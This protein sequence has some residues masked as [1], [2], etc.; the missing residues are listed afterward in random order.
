MVKEWGKLI[1]VYALKNAVEH[2]G[3]ALE[4]SIIAGLFHEGLDKEDVKDIIGTIKSE[5]K[6][7]NSLTIEEQ[8]K[9]YEKLSKLASKRE[10]RVGLQELPE[11]SKNMV[12]RIAPEP[13]KYN[14]IGHAFTFLINYL[15][16]RK[17]KGKCKLRF[18]DTNPE[19]AK[20]EYVD[21]MK[22]DIKYLGIEV[23]S[24]RF[25]SDDMPKL[26][27]YSEQ[28]IKMGKAF[29]CFCKQEKMK[30]LREQGKECSCRQHDV[31][32]N[33]SE[34]K[35]FLEGKYMNGEAT[36]RLKGIMTSNN[37]V[38]RD[39]VI[40]RVIKAEHYKKK[41]KVWPMYD[42]YNP[43]EDSLMGVTHILRSNEF[44]VRVELHNYIRDLL[45]L[46][47][48][49]IIQYGRINVIG[50]STKGREIRDL[51]AGKGYMGWDDPRLVTLLAL[52]R[53]GIVKEAFYELVE[54]IGISNHQ[55]NLSF[56]MIA[57]IN[58]KIL[59][60]QANRYSFVENPVKLEI[61]K[62]PD[63]KEIKV[64]VHPD[65]KETRV[66]EIG[67][68]FISEKDYENSK[69]KEARLMHLFN[70]N[71]GDKAEFA[72]L[73][74]KN[75]AR[76]NWVSDFVNARIMMPDATWITGIAEIAVKK[77]KL[78]SIIQFERF[79]FVRFDKVNG[80]G[81]YEFWFAHR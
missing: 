41:Y 37:Y 27:K 80:A 26:Y 23:A 81:E 32:K 36:L 55:V 53:R 76:I 57:A 5:V 34:W 71:L 46:K 16:A 6:R 18:E 45:K 9:Q 77:L 39:P 49:V 11:V 13:S 78:G 20:K 54:Q 79:G 61:K 65:K 52:R 8:K 2:E 3:K 69:G 4:G 67:E 51:V 75:I 44:E 24:I 35:K 59:D 38:M 68:I 58:R 42:F 64:K 25:V 17:Y 30:K 48:Q 29:M 33:M 63:I 47:K 10:E 12:F 40:F 15:Y 74:N 21:A 14:H 43:I 70:V 62:F 73:E 28:L 1:E 31:K 66:V 7:I 19:K 72:S 50:A 60:K 22:E 56:D